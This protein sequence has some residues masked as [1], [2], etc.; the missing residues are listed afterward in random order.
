MNEPKVVSR[1]EWNDMSATRLGAQPGRRVLD[2]VE[3]TIA[4]P[5]GRRELLI[6]AR[7]GCQQVS[8]TATESRSCASE[9]YR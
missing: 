1:E 9:R 2:I 7:K 6:G 8:S 5:G 3:S 4:G